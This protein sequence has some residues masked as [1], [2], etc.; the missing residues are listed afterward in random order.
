MRTTILAGRFEQIAQADAALSALRDAGF[1]ADETASF[2]VNPRGQHALYPIGGDTDDSRA[3]HQA[4]AGSGAGTAIGGVLGAALGA[5]ALPV[6]APAAV[7]VGAAVAAGVGAYGGSLIG[8]LNKLGDEV[9]PDQKE[10]AEK[11]AEEHM[12]PRKAGMLVA[13]AADAS[14]L[15]DK[16]ADVLRAQGAM[17]IERSSGEIAGGDWVDFDPLKPVCLLSGARTTTV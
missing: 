11:S 4:P 2:F 5:A 6:A 14:E 7:V 10:A 16:A 17:D 12:P 1:T 15:Q 13:V 9:P 8:T 3:A